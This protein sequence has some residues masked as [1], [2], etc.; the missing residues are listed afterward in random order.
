MEASQFSGGGAAGSG[1]FTADIT[2]GN[3][4]TDDDTVSWRL[5]GTV[6]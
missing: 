2:L 6:S 1:G 4:G 5:D 3:P